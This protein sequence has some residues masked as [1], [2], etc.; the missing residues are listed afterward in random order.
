MSVYLPSVCSTFVREPNATSFI[1]LRDPTAVSFKLVTE[2]AAP[3]FLLLGE[4]T[5]ASLSA[6]L[7][8]EVRLSALEVILSRLA[9][10]A[11][12]MLSIESVKVELSLSKVGRSG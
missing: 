3:S 5:E 12:V 10:A 11:L 8:P 2:P 4:L 6:L 9:V 1:L 7:E